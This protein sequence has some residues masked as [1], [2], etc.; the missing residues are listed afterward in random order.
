[1]SFDQF[2]DIVSKKL[3]QQHLNSNQTAERYR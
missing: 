2:S 1:M 3:K